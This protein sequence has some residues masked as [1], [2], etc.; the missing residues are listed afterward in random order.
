MYV[1]YDVKLLDPGQ[2]GNVWRPNTIKHCLV[3]KHANFEVNGQTV[4]TCLI[5]RRSNNWYKPLSKSGVKHVWYAAVQKNKTSPIEHENKH[6]QTQSNSTKQSV[7]TVKWLVTKQGLMVF[8]RQT[9][10]VCP[11]KHRCFP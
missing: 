9:F 4:K 2:T 6:D 10:P 5:K 7:Q 3:T 8:G 1:S 11:G